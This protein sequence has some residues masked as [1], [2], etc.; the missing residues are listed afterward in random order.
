MAGFSLMINI[1]Q[2]HQGTFVPTFFQKDFLNGT[3]PCSLHVQDDTGTESLLESL[4]TNYF[5][6]IS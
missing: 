3:L 2:I 5:L 4:N 6:I 1:R